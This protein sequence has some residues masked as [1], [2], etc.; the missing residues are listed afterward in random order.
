MKKLFKKCIQTQ[1]HYIPIHLQPWYQ[2]RYNRD[3]KFPSSESFYDSCLS[4]PLFPDLTE[5][6]LEKV[7]KLINQI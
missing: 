6:E 5:I 3:E 2:E 1:V 7:I 4:I